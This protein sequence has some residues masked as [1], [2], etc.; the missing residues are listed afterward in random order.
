MNLCENCHDEMHK[1]EKKYKRT[2][3]TKGITLEEI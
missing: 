1:T 3:T 2:K